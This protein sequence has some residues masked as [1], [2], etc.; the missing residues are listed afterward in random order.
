MTPE[1]RGST[2]QSTRI[3]SPVSL[4][5]ELGGHLSKDSPGEGGTVRGRSR[6]WLTVCAGGWQEASAPGRVGICTGLLE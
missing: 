5:Q 6:S 1:L 2:E 3:L 4:G